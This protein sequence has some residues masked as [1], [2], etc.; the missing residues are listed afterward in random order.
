[1]VNKAIIVGRLGHDASA[2]TTADGMVISNFSVAT[3]ERRKGEQ[4]TEWHSVVAFGKLA[5]IC[6]QYLTK[7]K[8]VYVSGKIQTR[9]WDDKDGNRKSRT[10]II[11]DEMQML[12]SKPD[13]GGIRK[14]SD[15]PAGDSIPF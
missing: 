11:A 5:E 1:M 9:T 2:R 13:N 10:E 12:D 3:D 6:N 15:I 4:V 14:Q 7:G 8:L